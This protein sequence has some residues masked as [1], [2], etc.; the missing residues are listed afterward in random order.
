MQTLFVGAGN[1]IPS[2]TAPESRRGTNGLRIK[3]HA[4]LCRTSIVISKFYLLSFGTFS[5]QSGDVE[6]QDTHVHRV[7]LEDSGV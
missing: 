5:I 6:V 7:T 2:A 1:P 3:I 4:L